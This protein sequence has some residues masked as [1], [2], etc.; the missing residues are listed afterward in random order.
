MSAAS[1]GEKKPV[2]STCATDSACV[3]LPGSQLHEAVCFSTV[4]T[5]GSSTHDAADP[6]AL[7]K[8]QPAAMH[9]QMQMMLEDTGTAVHQ[10]SAV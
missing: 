7:Q 3:S 4:L 1:A 9:G 10:A 2:C 5:D 8:L 6:A